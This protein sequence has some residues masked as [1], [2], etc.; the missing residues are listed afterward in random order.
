MPTFSF[1]YPAAWRVRRSGACA[2]LDEPGRHPGEYT[3]QLC[4]EASALP[5]VADKQG[6]APGDDGAWLR[7][8]GMDAPSP[9]Q[10]MF[11]PGWSGMVT[12]QTCGISDAETGFHAAGGTCLMFAGSDGRRAVLADSVGFYQDFRRLREILRSIRFEPAPTR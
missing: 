11:G 5:A 7:S 12:T 2:T 10:W 9:V 3:L 8:Y 4:A 6:F 1:A